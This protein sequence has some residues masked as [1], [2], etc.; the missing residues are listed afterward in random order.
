VLEL[1]ELR[2]RYRS[3]VALDGLTFAVPHGQVFGFLGI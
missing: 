3:V 1:T 2:R